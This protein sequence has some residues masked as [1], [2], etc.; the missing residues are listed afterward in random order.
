M[1]KL[2]LLLM[3]F[4]NLLAFE[5]SNIQ[6]LYGDFNGNSYVFDTKNNSAKYT[7]T[8]EHYRTFAY[9][10][11][12]MFFDA[13]MPQSEYRYRDEDKD[14]YAE[15]AP[16]IDI[17]KITDRDLSF[18]FVKSIHLAF[19]YNR[20]KKYEAYLFG[21]SGNLEIPGFDVFGLSVYKK[22]QNIGENNYQLTLNYKSKTLY[23]IF[24]LSGFTDW[25]EFDFLSQNQFLF[26]VADPFENHKLYI[27]AEWHYYRQKA[28]ENNFYKKVTSNALQAMIKY[29][30]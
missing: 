23:D 2:F 19:Q 11:V 15:I 12:F 21:L 10:D 27:G 25:T 30:W 17:G 5:T 28:I 6:L 4:Y 3:M 22:N 13:M 7:I 8:A 1:K 18:S 9:G 24:H 26:K 29:S 16:R 14:I 20:G